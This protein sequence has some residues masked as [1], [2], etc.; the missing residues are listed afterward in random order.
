[1]TPQ[2]VIT[3]IIVCTLIVW[4]VYRQTREQQWPIGRMW[5]APILFLVVTASITAMDATMQPL[6]IPAAIAG[7]VAG[8]ALGLYQGTHTVLRVDKPGRAVFIKVTP[9]GS[10]IFIAVLVARIA[11]RSVSIGP[12]LQQQAATGAL[13]VMTLWEAMLGSGLLALAA[14]SVAG[15]R[16]YVQRAFDAVPS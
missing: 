1:M 7:L 5:V 14:G 2:V 11:I 8:V 4:R 6:A 12:A 13:P 9:I 16:W 3:I 10:V 15:L